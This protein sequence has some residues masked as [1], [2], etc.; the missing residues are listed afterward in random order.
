MKLVVIA[1][2]ACALAVGCGS[3]S[4]DDAT[5]LGSMQ[6]GTTTLDIEQEGDGV[7]PGKNARFVLKPTSGDK[8]TSI[9]G[10]IGV[11]SGQGSE[12]KEAVYDS[13]DGDYD[14]DVAVPDP[15]PAG[16]RFWFTVTV[17]ERSDTASIP[18]KK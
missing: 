16:A 11:E 5:S 18:W 10:W 13:G 15:I 12:K 2:F 14:D 6:V 3:S 7:V 9:V 1:S 17:G 4:S 8:P